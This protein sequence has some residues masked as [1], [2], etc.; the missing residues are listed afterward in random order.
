MQ[1]T[2]RTG[3]PKKLHMRGK[4]LQQIGTNQRPTSVLDKTRFP[5]DEHSDF[6]WN[7]LSYMWVIVFLHS[8]GC[9]SR[10]ISKWH[11]QVDSDELSREMCP[12]FGVSKIGSTKLWSCLLG[13]PTPNRLV[14]IIEVFTSQW[15]RFNHQWFG[16]IQGINDRTKC[17][18]FPLGFLQSFHSIGR[19]FEDACRQ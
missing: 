4:E 9:T 5:P 13:K 16:L 10:T 1:R 7:I 11:F 15:S 17:I 19:H 3:S 18:F 6:W 2:L 14:A 12:N 8:R